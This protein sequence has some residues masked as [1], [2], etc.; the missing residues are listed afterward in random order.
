MITK[1][2]LETELNKE[3]LKKL[4]NLFKET[5]R[6]ILDS[7]LILT[8]SPELAGICRRMDMAVAA[9][10]SGEQK[11]FPGI[12]YAVMDV[13]NLDEK[14]L[15]K[16]WQRYRGIPWKICETKRCLVR[17][18]VQGDVD[19]FYRIYHDKSITAYMEDLYEDKEKERQYIRDYIEKVYGFYGFGMWTVCLKET[20][21]VIGRAG[22]SMREGFEE[23][24]LGYV[25]GKRWQKRGIA[26]EVCREILAYGKEE[27]GFE[28]V[29]V[30][31]HPENIASECLCNKLGFKYKE[32]Q[33]VDG[34]IYSAYM[35]RL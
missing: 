14:Y 29:R 5:K 20:G 30:L 1:I 11:E 8:D 26:T 35:L 23:P 16:I 2:I 22:L 32:E 4:E 9:V 12:S 10:L 13:D 34:A 24:E 28:Q 21:E 3:E 25:I 18:T 27:L 7:F 17:E 33:E 31:M 6:D 15:E 19:S